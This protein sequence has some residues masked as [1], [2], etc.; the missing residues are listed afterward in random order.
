VSNIRSF[1][2]KFGQTYI[3]FII[4]LAFGLIIQGLIF[5]EMPLQSVGKIALLQVFLL[6]GQTI[7]DFGTN[8]LST[9]LSN[10][11]KSDASFVITRSFA[12]ISICALA[13]IVSLL[14]NEQYI[15]HALTVTICLM[16]YAIT[17]IWLYIRSNNYTTLLKIQCFSKFNQLVF[18][19][20]AL[21]ISTLSPITV[22]FS[23]SIY[24]F[25]SF[26]FIFIHRNDFF[27]N[28][29]RHIQFKPDT[30]IFLSGLTITISNLSF[31]F[32]RTIPILILG[33]FGNLEQV[34]IFSACDRIA[35]AISQLRSPIFPQLMYRIN[36]NDSIEKYNIIKKYL[37]LIALLSILISIFA[38][39]TAP[40]LTKIVY[41]AKVSNNLNEFYYYYFPVIATQ[42]ILS[43]QLACVFPSIGAERHMSKIS[44]INIFCLATL[45]A[46]A[47]HAWGLQMFALAIVASDIGAILFGLFVFR[48][49][50]QK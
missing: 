36:M 6:Y 26:L 22:F 45:S 5:R 4:E 41:G 32:A 31:N 15:K 40:I 20:I 11:S 37:L 28:L 16:I 7:T 35:N 23:F 39:I 43:F 38:I 46:G 10:N 2:K 19:F 47:L 29:K 17:P 24:Y 33:F 13:L 50:Y 21:N 48:K 27:K 8:T 44:F 34:A 18:I 3:P 1:S 14:F 25:S 30:K 9:I 49:C 12:A 42:I